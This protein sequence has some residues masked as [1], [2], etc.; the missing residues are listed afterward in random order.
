MLAFI[1]VEVM[2]NISIVPHNNK[3]KKLFFEFS[4]VNCRTVEFSTSKLFELC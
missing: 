1:I 2:C 4:I 3:F